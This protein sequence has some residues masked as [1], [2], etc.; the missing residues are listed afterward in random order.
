MIEMYIGHLHRMDIENARKIVTYELESF[1]IEFLELSVVSAFFDKIK[2]E[3]YYMFI[4]KNELLGH[5]F[6]HKFIISKNELYT[7]Q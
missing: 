6:F 5:N 4:E 3:Q 1:C 7:D 2:E